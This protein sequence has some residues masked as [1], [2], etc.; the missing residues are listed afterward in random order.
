M[1]Y[2]DAFV[3][4][5]F[6]GKR[7]SLNEAYAMVGKATPQEKQAYASVSEKEFQHLS[8]YKMVQTD[9][10]GKADEDSKS[11]YGTARGFIQT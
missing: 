11:F 10:D 7:I 5:Y 4:A 1:N 3:V 8:K 9:F 6:N 2:K